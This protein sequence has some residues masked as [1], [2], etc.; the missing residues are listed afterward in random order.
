M[1]LRL[2]ESEFAVCK[3]ADFTGVD[4][5]ADFLFMAKT[6]EEYSIVCPVINMPENP[7]AVERSWRAI[8]IE[9]VLDFSL[10]GIIAKIS[11]ILAAHGI[12]VFVVSTFNTDYIL[13]KE[14]NLAQTIE[15]LAQEGYQFVD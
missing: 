10:V 7:I 12:S 1:N 13:V 6:D 8:K 3:V 5:Q 2:L 4:Y 15:A 11:A 9:G 14:C